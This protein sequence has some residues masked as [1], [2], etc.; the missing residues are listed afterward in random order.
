MTTQNVGVNEN[1]GALAPVVNS[2][3]TQ[4]PAQIVE[5]KADGQGSQSADS[6]KP[7]NK[8]PETVPYQRFKEV[9]EKAKVA[10]ELAA[11]YKENLAVFAALQELAKAN[12][13]FASEFKGVID[14][15]VGD[16][17]PAKPEAKPAPQDSD[18]IALLTK[19]VKSLK[20]ERQ[21]EKSVS[22]VDMYDK[23]HEVKAASEVPQEL[24]EA[25]DQMVAERVVALHKGTPSF[26]DQKILDKAYDDTK[27]L[28]E[29]AM[30]KLKV[31][32]PVAA[33]KD[34]PANASGNAP[35]TTVQIPKTFE[36]RRALIQR[37][38]ESDKR[39]F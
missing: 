13:D 16:D 7:E 6:L 1:G 30:N 33:A 32:A 34:V 27:K 2:P 15:Y 24:R 20:A 10:E 22:A 21:A 26:F 25:F 18:P 36:E 37:G 14:K 28:F 23:T 8:I 31:V 38:L 11:T 3:V 4:T 19:E 17:A 9:N 12:P 29:P 35:V 39:L 5:S